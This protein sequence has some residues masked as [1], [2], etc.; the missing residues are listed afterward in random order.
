M[1]EDRAARQTLTAINHSDVVQ[2]KKTAFENVVALAIH[3]VH[4]PGKVDEQLVEA[5]L[6][7]L[8]VANAMALEVAVVDAPNGPGVHRRI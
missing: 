1:F 7:K 3:F 5:L 8:L 2:T 4:P 6:Q